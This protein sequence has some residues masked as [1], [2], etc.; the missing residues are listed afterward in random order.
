MPGAWRA[1][2]RRFD[3]SLPGALQ[4]FEALGHRSSAQRAR[5]VVHRAPSVVRAPASKHPR[6]V[7]VLDATAG[8]ADLLPG[9]AVTIPAI[10]HRY[11]KRHLA[12]ACSSSI[13]RMGYAVRVI[14]EARVRPVGGPTGA[15]A[16]ACAA[17]VAAL[18]PQLT[19]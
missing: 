13:Q 10:L 11:N 3:R 12:V 6:A 2:R 4:A 18:G 16:P 9:R 19:C 1:V 8:N 17:G 15:G 5:D 7:H 14:P